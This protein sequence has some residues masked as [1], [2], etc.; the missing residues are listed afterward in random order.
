MEKLESMDYS[1]DNN[2][3]IDAVDLLYSLK[4][5]IEADGN[6]IKGKDLATLIDNAKL[7]NRV[8]RK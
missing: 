6:I 3:L 2:S 5:L 8:M 1:I 7:E 4:A